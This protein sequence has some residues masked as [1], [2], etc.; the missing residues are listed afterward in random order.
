MVASTVRLAV[1]ALSGGRTERRS[2]GYHP[3]LGQL[4]ADHT[5]F[6]HR[7]R[8]AALG[9]R[10]GFGARGELVR[11][12]RDGEGEKDDGKL[13]E[14]GSVTRRERERPKAFGTLIAYCIS[15]VPSVRRIFAETFGAEVTCESLIS[16][17]SG[18]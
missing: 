9:D 12:E 4:P 3:A 7:H 14:E 17:H 15:K 10:E 5:I 1:L 2:P 8:L 16:A 6:A 11:G 13:H 18:R